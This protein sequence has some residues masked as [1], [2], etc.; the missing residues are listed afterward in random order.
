MAFLEIS[1]PFACAYG[2]TGGERFSTDVST[3]GGGFEQRNANFDTPLREWRL[4]AVNKSQADY[5]TLRN[6]FMVAKGRANGF[7]FKDFSDFQLASE[8]IG[9]GTG[10]LA[11]FQLKKAYVF[12]AFSAS[13]DIKKPVTGTLSLTVN[14]VAKTQGVHYNADFTTGLITFTVGNLPANGHMIR[15][16]CDFDVP[17]RFD[18][19]L[20]DL[21]IN[22]RNNGGYI[23]NWDGILIKEIR[24]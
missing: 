4:S 1:F 19:D 21:E 6:F 18:N 16:S 17:A 5:L 8:N 3:T 22:A 12:G 9:T 20:M 14:N 10:S 15:A 7:R 13:R 24:L 2:A 11:V 23:G